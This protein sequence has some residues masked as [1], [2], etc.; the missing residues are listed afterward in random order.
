MANPKK[1]LHLEDDDGWIKIVKKALPDYEV[2]S[3]HSIPEAVRAY[4]DK[5]FD[6]AILDISLL[7]DDSQ[8]EQG[9]KFLNALEGLNVLPGKRIVILSAYLVGEEHQDRTRKYF[10]M[11]NVMDAI[12]KQKFNSKEFKVIIDDAVRTPL[13]S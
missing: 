11:Y 1:I 8:D 4:H 12:P 3:A 5:E 9:E 2:F 6:A 7:P 10:K 13:S